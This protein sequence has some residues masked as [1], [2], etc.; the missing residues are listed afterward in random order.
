MFLIFIL[1]YYYLLLFFFIL[2]SLLFFFFFMI[3]IWIWVLVH[4]SKE[5]IN[6]SFPNFFL[7]IVS[8]ILLDQIIK[9]FLMLYWYLCIWFISLFCFRTGGNLLNPTPI[10]ETRWG[11]R[12]Q[13]RPK[14]Y[15]ILNGETHQFI[16]LQLMK[17]PLYLPT[18]TPLKK[19]YPQA[20]WLRLRP[21]WKFC[22]FLPSKCSI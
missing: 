12:K 8:D 9:I 22:H 11:K 2:L 14:S 18:R 16:Q 5:V 21:S 4:T 10:K 7:L 20:Y 13:K 3:F 19:C 15:K 6:H 1:F 17:L